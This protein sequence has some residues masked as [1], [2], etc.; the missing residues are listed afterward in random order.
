MV[1]KYK[2]VNSIS[3]SVGM[4]VQQVFE[5]HLIL[6]NGERVYVGMT[7]WASGLAPNPLISH[8][9]EKKSFPH[10]N[11]KLLLDHHLSVMPDIY[12]LGDCAKIREL[13]LPATA[14]VAK[15]QAQYLARTLLSPA[16]SKTKDGFQFQNWGSMAYVGDQKAVVDWPRGST[17]RGWMA[18]LLWR[19]AYFSMTVSWRN[20]ALIPMYWFL[21]WVFGR[22]MTNI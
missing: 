10:E 17:W 15:Q 19:S 13:N 6:S 1:Y 21:T 3:F 9:I 18:W 4:S 7:V 11:N 22:D 2:Q 16:D 20:K 8:L 14:Q 12:A 5:D